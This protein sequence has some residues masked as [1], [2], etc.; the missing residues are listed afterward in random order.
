LRDHA[1]D[2][3]RIEFSARDIY[4][5]ETIISCIIYFAD[6]LSFHDLSISPVRSTVI[7][8]DCACDCH[9]SFDLAHCRFNH[10]KRLTISRFAGFAYSL[11]KE[12][13]DETAAIEL[14]NNETDRV[15][16]APRAKG[17]IEV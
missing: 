13:A 4:F 9:S 3:H 16:P 6:E 10:R 12:L 8:F 14:H 2:K 17:V 15:T 5:D 7:S 1:R 11:P